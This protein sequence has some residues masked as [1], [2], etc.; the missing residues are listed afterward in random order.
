MWAIDTRLFCQISAK[1][2]I[3]P[4]NTSLAFLRLVGS[5][6]L[7]EI[8]RM[9]FTGIGLSGWAWETKV[10]GMTCLLICF[11]F[12]ALFVLFVFLEGES[13]W[14]KTESAQ[15][16]NSLWPCQVMGWAGDKK[17]EEEWDDRGRAGQAKDTILGNDCCVF[18]AVL[19]CAGSTGWGSGTY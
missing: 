3:P 19:A 10:L 1:H 8:T 15:I 16:G 12:V 5:H 13:Q 11:A 7:C 9:R 17:E 4:S 18:P 2:E 6:R 14:K